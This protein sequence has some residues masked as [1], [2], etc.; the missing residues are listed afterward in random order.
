MCLVHIILALPWEVNCILSIG[1]KLLQFRDG[2]EENPGRGLRRV[3]TQVDSR[4]CEPEVLS[5]QTMPFPT[6]EQGR[7][8]WQDTRS[9]N[10]NGAQP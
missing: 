7:R 9:A 1:H 6:L 2:L 4:N 5:V 3:R 8:G 10:Q